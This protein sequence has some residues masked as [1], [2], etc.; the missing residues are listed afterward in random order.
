MVPIRKLLLISLLLLFPARGVF[1]QLADPYLRST[2]KETQIEEILFTGNKTVDSSLI[3]GS[4]QFRKG[5]AFL[6]PVFRQHVK[7]S[8]EALYRLRLFSDIRVDIAYPSDREGAVLT[9]HFKEL[10]TLAGTE[11]QGNKKIKEDD[12][13]GAMTLLDGQVYSPSAVEKD[14][15]SI[16]DLYREKGFLLAKVDYTEK[17]ETGSGRNTLTFTIDEGR[18]VSVR[19]I[20]FAGNANFKDK[21]LRKRLSVKEDRWWRDGDFKQDEFRVSLDSIVD[22]YREKG[23]L[24]AA[25]QGHEITYSDDKR[26]LDI[27]IKMAEGSR[28]YFGK[29]FFVHNNIVEDRALQAQVMLDS[30]EVFNVKKFEATKFQVQS[31][32]REQGYL[33]VQL[34]DQRTYRGD[35]VDV[36]FTVKENSIAHIQKVHVRGNTKTKDKVVRREVRLFPGDIFRQSLVMRSQ[37]DIMQLNFF[38]GVEPNIEPSESGDPSEVDLVFDVKEKEA[39][40][41]TFSAGAAYQARDGFVGTLGLQ[42]PNFMGNGQRAEMNVEYGKYKELFSVGFT[43]PWLMDTP[44]LL[45]G[46]LFYSFYEARLA[47][48][49]D[50][51]SYGMRVSLGRRLTWPDDY[52]SVRTSYNLTRNDNGQ[53]HDASNLIIP[54]G[55]ES[56]ISATIVRDDKDLPVFPTEGSRYALTLSQVGG[57]LQGSF[58]Y[59]QSDLKVNWWF[60]TFSK[61]VLGVETQFGMIYGDNIQSRSLYQMGGLLGY[62]GKLRG[63]SPG[64]IGNSR[65]GRSFFSFVTELSY[66]IVPGTLYGLAFFDAGNVF[67]NLPKYTT[68]ESGRLRF[69]AIPKDDAPNP[70]DEVDLTD[71]RR[72]IGLG[73]RLV[74][75][76][77]GIMGFDFGW[78][79][80]DEEVIRTGARRKQ[81]GKMQVNFVVEQGF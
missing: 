44:T 19:Y 45:G 43:E 23:F 70:F 66:P 76:M 56:S 41:G 26:H 74:V 15:Q 3:A 69:T 80:D 33:F 50:Y 73:F 9:F 17:V 24:D 77:V 81:D 30:G 48:E 60:P 34:A 2:V 22:F 8:V 72:D 35:T 12:I 55:L 32:Y 13:R 27:R 18:K 79:L 49:F 20:T 47:N 16:L 28:Y 63:Y 64:S 5:E 1:A 31:I 29:A 11:L 75:P 71:L 36:T 42:I 62:Q 68:D 4:L 61:F 6:P 38:D 39:G 14:R 67:G 46:S 40:T 21:E 25:V 10:P 51:T 52:F 57:P 7:T 54:S 78:G 37:R 59:V 58:D 65:V 53:N